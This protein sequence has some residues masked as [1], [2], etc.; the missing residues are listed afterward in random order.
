[1]KKILTASLIAVSLLGASTVAADAAVKK[2]TAAAKEGTAKHEA[3]ESKTT[4]KT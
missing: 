2:P 4:Q 3:A 1:M